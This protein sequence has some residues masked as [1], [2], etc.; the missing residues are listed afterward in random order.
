MN[1][2]RDAANNILEIIDKTF[3]LGK[4]DFSVARGSA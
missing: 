3:V 1:R 2:D 4:P